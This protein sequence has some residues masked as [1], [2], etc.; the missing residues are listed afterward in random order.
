M[1]ITTVNIY[2]DDWLLLKRI[3]YKMK[4]GKQAVGFAALEK[5]SLENDPFNLLYLIFSTIFP[6]NLFF[7]MNFF[8]P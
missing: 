7:R 3:Q 2:I 1:S 5:L 6:V 8:S 4:Q